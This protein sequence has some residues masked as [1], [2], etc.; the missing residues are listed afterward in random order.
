MYI[1]YKMGVFRGICV[2]LCILYAMIEGAEG[3]IGGDLVR[4][5]EWFGNDLRMIEK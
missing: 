1:M 5:Y 2:Y 3:M 4:V